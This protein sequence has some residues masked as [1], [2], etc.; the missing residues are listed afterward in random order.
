MTGKHYKAGCLSLVANLECIHL[1]RDPPPACIWTIA[2]GPP[3]PRSYLDYHKGD[4]LPP[5]RIWT[6]AR[7]TPPPPRIWTGGP[8]K[9]VAQGP[10]QSKSCPELTNQIVRFHSLPTIVSHVHA[11]MSNFRPWINWSYDSF[12]VT[13]HCLHLII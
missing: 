2:R 6:I 9:L 10:Q 8:P 4:P 1:E 13:I 3:L 11:S 12:L 7:G 5:T